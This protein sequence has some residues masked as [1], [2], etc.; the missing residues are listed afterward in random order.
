MK[1]Y[2]E[3]DL[4]VR[5]VYANASNYEAVV[6]ELS[7]LANDGNP[8]AAFNLGGLYE[9]GEHVEQSNANAI[10]YY[11]LADKLGLIEA[12]YQLGVTCEFGRCGVG[13]SHEVAA[14]IYQE[15]ADLGHSN[16]QCQ[17]GGLYGSGKGVE[18]NLERALHY[19]RLAS[20]SGN[21]RA[22]FLLAD[23]YMNGLGTSQSVTEALIL[24]HKAANAGHGFSQL[25]L[26]TKYQHGDDLP[27]DYVNAYKYANMAYESA[28]NESDKKAALGLRDSI[29]ARMSDDEKRVCFSLDQSV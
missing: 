7:S 25:I 18:K 26:A 20:D 12:K 19:Y 21:A 2:E 9:I 11:V 22:T 1:T 14:K 27:R 29:F 8:I 23:S 17:L 4:D 6:Q 3:F 5:N 28:K 15:A 13:Q 10:A 24:Y 16:A